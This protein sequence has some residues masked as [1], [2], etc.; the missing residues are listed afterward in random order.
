MKIARFV[1]V[2]FN[3]IDY[4]IEECIFYQVRN[5]NILRRNLILGITGR[6]TQ[7]SRCDSLQ[8][9]LSCNFSTLQINSL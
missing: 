1:W 6:D 4:F 3:G 5:A 2:I 7:M 8:D 9:L